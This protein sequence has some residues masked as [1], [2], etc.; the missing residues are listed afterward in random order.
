MQEKHVA[1][2]YKAN[3]QEWEA[4]QNKINDKRNKLFDLKMETDMF[5]PEGKAEYDRLRG[6]GEKLDDIESKAH[7]SY[8]KK[9]SDLFALRTKLKYERKLDRSLIREATKKRKEALIGAGVSGAAALG[10]GAY[11]LHNDTQD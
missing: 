2:D 9:D 10:L 6:L 11:A 7:K 3:K 5:T 1:R 4:L 8:L